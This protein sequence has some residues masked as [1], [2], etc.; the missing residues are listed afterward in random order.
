MCIGRGMQPEGHTAVSN[1]IMDKPG[2]LRRIPWKIAL[3]VITLGVTIVLLRLDEICLVKG[4]GADD[5]PV[6]SAW[7]LLCLL[8]WPVFFLTSFGS[9]WMNG[10]F[11][12][13]NLYVEVHVAAA[14]LF[15][16]LMGWLLDRKL[17]GRIDP[18]IRSRAIRIGLYTLGLLVALF[19][20]LVGIPETIGYARTWIHFNEILRS[21]WIYLLG[22]EINSLAAAIWGLTST[23]YF[24]NRLLGLTLKRAH[25]AT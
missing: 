9:R 18:L 2:F 13:L 7:G 5:M 14:L 22:R 20:L 3:P 23:L 24:G 4:R 21:K 19:A 6:S 1:S 8:H 11:L 12:G 17:A 10:E 25:S 15:W 16:A